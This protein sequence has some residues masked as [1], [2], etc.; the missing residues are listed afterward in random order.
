MGEPQTLPGVRLSDVALLSR[1]DGWAVGSAHENQ[2]PRAVI[3]RLVDGRWQFHSTLEKPSTWLISLWLAGPDEGSALGGRGELVDFD[4][5]TWTLAF[6][7]SGGLHDISGAGPKDVWAVGGTE[8]HPFGAENDR[9]V[10][11]HFDGTHWEKAREEPGVGWATIHLREDGRGF[12]VGF[13]GQLDVYAGGRWADRGRSVYA[14]RF[15]WISDVGLL[16]GTSD[17][18]ISRNDG[19]VYR[20]A[21]NQVT[22]ANTIAEVRAIE[23]L[24][25]DRGWAFGY[26]TALAFDGARWS[27]LDPESPLNCVRDIDALGPTDAWAVGDD[28]RILRWDGEQWTDFPSPTDVDLSRVR[29]ISP[30]CAWALGANRGGRAK[31]VVLRFNGA[32]W[33]VVLER[34]G[35]QSFEFAD[36][37]ALGPDRAW[38]VGAG[39]LHRFTA[40]AWTQIALPDDIR[41]LDVVTPDTIWLG[42]SGE[43]YRSD[44]V[45]FEPV[46]FFPAG[47]QVNHI[48]M[49]PDGTGWAVGWYGYV[50]RF[51]GQVWRIVR[52]PADPVGQGGVPYALY[53]IDTVEDS[54]ETHIY[55]SGAPNSI[56]HTTLAEIEA[57]PAIT[58]APTE[59]AQPTIIVRPMGYLPSLVNLNP[60]W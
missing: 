12:A 53:D 26:N 25:P 27:N 11:W 52:G 20:V 59:K 46:L 3:Y 9:R 8:P 6:E 7:A 57:R 50:M 31:G 44:G 29:A 4:G 16:P 51:D 17:A 54:G 37:D 40:G 49:L 55:V 48:R 28:G 5:Q 35:A 19:V 36:I 22:E 42:G 58:P 33:E 21:D 30:D 34:E 60:S 13:E 10:M 43:I 1:S 39:V 32:S 47:A 2:S 41:S 24:A 18:F 45:A 14:N 23:M 15:F 56:L 38:V